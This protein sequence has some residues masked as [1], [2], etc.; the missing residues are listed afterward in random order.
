MR[1][2]ES[3]V[4]A[5][6]DLAKALHLAPKALTLPEG[7]RSARGERMPTDFAVHKALVRLPHSELR[8]PSPP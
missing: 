6:E 7:S 5:V 2:A 8:T 3:V 4:A 1:Q